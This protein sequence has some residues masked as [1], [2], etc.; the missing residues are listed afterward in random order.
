MPRLALTFVGGR[1]P[2]RE[3]RTRSRPA[4]HRDV[5]SHAT[6]EPAT[7]GEPEPRA[8]F[9]ASQRAVRLHEWLEQ[10]AHELGRDAG[11]RVADAD[12]RP[13]ASRARSFGRIRSRLPHAEVRAGVGLVGGAA[14]DR[15]FAGRWRELHRVRE[16]VH[17]NLSHAPLVANVRRTRRV[18]IQVEHANPFRRRLRVHERR[19]RHDCGAGHQ[20]IV[21]NVEAV[22]VDFRDI[23][24]VIDELQQ[25]TRARL[26]AL[27]MRV[28][29]GCRRPEHTHVEQLRVTEDGVERRAKLV[30]HRGE[31]FRLPASRIIGGGD[32]SRGLATRRLHRELQPRCLD[33]RGRAPGEIL[34]HLTLDLG[35]PPS[36]LRSDNGDRS[37][38]R[39][40]RDHGD[41]HVRAYAQLLEYYENAAD[42]SPA[43]RA[44]EQRSR[45]RSPAFPRR[46]PARRRERHR[47]AGDNAR[48][49]PACI[50]RA[51]RMSAVPSIAG[52]RRHRSPDR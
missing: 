40:V 23:E 21:P 9:L 15:D 48:E 3:D 45:R 30:A 10:A 39:A 42:L 35:E 24:H 37:E 27:E 19:G 8:T 2:E 17:E 22:R 46:S 18:V 33:R 12:I 52:S 16:E 47:E 4:A 25:V 51:R 11:A 5:A 29:C 28:L 43:P 7:D 50:C 41:A 14:D 13:R 44:R 31:E 34:D 20:H 49:A 26:Q 1:E 38:S 36:F 6:G 32:R